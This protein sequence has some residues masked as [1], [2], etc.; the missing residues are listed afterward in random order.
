MFVTR[1]CQNVKIN[2]TE[3]NQGSPSEEDHRDG[4]KHWWKSQREIS[5]LKNTDV[6]LILNICPCTP[7]RKS[8][9]TNRSDALE[10]VR[11]KSTDTD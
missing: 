2:S 6:F 10:R 5:L 11:L 3:A 1:I 4:C 9:G 7:Q 8:D